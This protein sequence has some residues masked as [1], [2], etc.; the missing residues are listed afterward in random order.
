MNN[1]FPVDD[2]KLDKILKEISAPPKKDDALEDYLKD[3]LKRA[4]IP[5]EVTAAEGHFSINIPFDDGFEGGINGKVSEGRLVIDE[6]EV[7][8]VFPD[9]Y[10]SAGVHPQI[11]DVHEP[12]PMGDPTEKKLIGA[13]QKIRDRLLEV[14]KP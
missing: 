13:F 7:G 3:L 9:D 6:I 2:P 8:Q 11:W 4:E 10:I 5:A 14:I 1:D 12:I